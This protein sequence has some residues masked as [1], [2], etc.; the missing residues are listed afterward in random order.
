LKR[1]NQSICP[2]IVLPLALLG[3]SLAVFLTYLIP[4]WRA[5]FSSDVFVF[6]NG[7]DEEFYLSLQG[8]LDVRNTPGYF[9][10]YLNLALHHL[11][12]SGAVQNLV[13]DTV[14]PPATAWL[15][16][17]T[18]QLRKVDPVRA[19]AYA[20]LICFGSVLFNANNPLISRMLGETRNNSIWIM[21]GWEV[22]ASILR[23]PNPEIP[24]FLVACAVYAFVRFNKWWI[25]LLP[26]PL[27]YYH[28]AVPYAF[29]LLLSFSYH[30]LRS[31]YSANSVAALLV[32]SVVTLIVMGSGLT[33]LSYLM[34]LYQPDHP[35]RQDPYIFS[36]TRHPQLPVGLIVMGALFLLGVYFKFLQIESRTIVLIV[37]LAIASLGSINLHVA[38]GFMLSQKNY[39]DYGLSIFFALLVVIAIE[40]IR[41]DVARS[42]V[43]AGTL[44]AIALFSYR[45]QQIWFRNGMLL[46]QE[47]AP[48]IERLRLDPLHAIIPKIE[49]SAHVAF[50]TPLLL[51]P[52]FSYLY[53][54]AGMIDQC[55]LLPALVTDAFIFA[56]E[57]LPA[58]SKEL[59]ELSKSAASI[60]LARKR[61]QRAT[62][63]PDLSY[64]RDADL[65][66]KD[67][68]FAGPGKP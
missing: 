5:F 11:D 52:P 51:S 21:S 18:L 33:T 13:F 20:T 45:S 24:F 59:T 29:L 4:E 7:W 54:Y 50:S 61:F 9:P 27:L 10:L 28:C 46:G 15:A 53:Y 60:E 35:W 3:C 16:F 12:L 65:E 38:T 23:T 8:I 26:L 32:A 1:G 25:L 19:I 41:T 30:Q 14:L 40:S 57:H 34:G 55:T 42:T 64:C 31:G 22:Y 44:V 36:A 17:L 67:F 63:K 68:Y 47:M 37:I 6:A 43:L 56:T 62:P 66:N 58:D 49:L 2:D 48:G 39:Y